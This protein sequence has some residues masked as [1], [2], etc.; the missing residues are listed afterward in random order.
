MENYHDDSININDINTYLKIQRNFDDIDY[1]YQTYDQFH[2]EYKR[3]IE[4][5]N[6]GLGM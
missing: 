3:I 2:P 1:I 4:L 5:F 6:F